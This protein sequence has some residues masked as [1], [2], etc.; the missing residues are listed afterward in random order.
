MA[1]VLGGRRLAVRLRNVGDQQQ[2]GIVGMP[3]ARQRV[4][5]VE[6]AEAAAKG[7][8]LLARDLLVAEQQDAALEEGAMDLVE[9]GVAERLGKIDALDL[10]AQGMAQR[11]EG[12]RHGDLFGERA[13]IMRFPRRA[14]NPWLGMAAPSPMRIICRVAN[15][16][17]Q[18]CADT[19]ERA[20]RDCGPARTC[21][22]PL[23][24][25]ARD[26]SWTPFREVLR[27]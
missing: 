10:G 24:W 23:G 20:E 3:V 26:S 13:V 17:F 8:V 18:A 6:L 15:S 1:G 12:K 11:T 9:L 7:D 5:T 16:T 2:L 21:V 25:P 22:Q 14:R 27:R 4:V 19:S